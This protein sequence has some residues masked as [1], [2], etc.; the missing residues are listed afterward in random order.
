MKPK[1]LACFA[2]T[3]VVS[4]YNERV[5]NCRRLLVV[6]TRMCISVAPEVIAKC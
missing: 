5:T 2:R 6:S 1:K 4:D 3:A